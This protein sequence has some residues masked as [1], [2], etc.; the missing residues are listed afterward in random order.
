M[1]I[2]ATINLTLLTADPSACHQQNMTMTYHI[3]GG[4]EGDREYIGP[5]IITLY[6]NIGSK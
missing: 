3:Q 1:K 2:D 6:L 4:R 5:A